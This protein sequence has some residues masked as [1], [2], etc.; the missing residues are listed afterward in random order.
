VKNIA[1]MLPPRDIP[2]KRHWRC[3]REASFFLEFRR[4]ANNVASA[5]RLAR[6]LFTQGQGVTDMNMLA[7]PMFWNMKIKIAI[8]TFATFAALC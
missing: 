8:L 5:V 2:P 4:W 6:S 7:S 1:K 3:R